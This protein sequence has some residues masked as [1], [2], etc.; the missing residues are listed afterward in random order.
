MNQHLKKKLQEQ[1][2]EERQ[3]I[4]KKVVQKEDK[5]GNEYGNDGEKMKQL[6]KVSRRNKIIKDKTIKAQKYDGFR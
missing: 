4:I 6:L 3:I 5:E 2:K 1:K